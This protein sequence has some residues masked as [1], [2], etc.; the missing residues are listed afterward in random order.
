MVQFLAKT[1][2]QTT[3][4]PNKNNKKVDR[5]HKHYYSTIVHHK[6]VPRMTDHTYIKLSF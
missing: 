4:T 6:R 5:Y 2:K 3:P 1:T